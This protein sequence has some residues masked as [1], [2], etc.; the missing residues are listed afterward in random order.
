[1]SEEHRSAAVLGAGVAGL[2]AARALH[3]R[4]FDVT[5]FEARDELGGVWANNYHSLRVLEPNCVY[6]YPDWPWPDG[7]ELFPPASQVREYLTS[8]ARHFGIFER[9]RFGTRITGASPEGSGGWRIEYESE[10]GARGERFDFFVMAPGMF[11]IPKIPDWPER[12]RFA[13]ELI[14]SSQYRD[15]EQV[16]DKR[17]AI[18]GFSRS[19]MDIAVNILDVAASVTI[20]HRSVRWPVPEKILGLIRNHLLLFSRWPTWF[21]PP[22]IRPTP[23]AAFLHGAGKPLVAG[24]WKFFELLL[25][26]QFR[27]RSRRLLPERPIRLDLFTNLYI[28]PPAFFRHVGEGRIHAAR[29]EIEG[30]DRDGL[31]LANGERIEADVVICATGW[32]QDYGFLPAESR[33]RIHDEDGMHLYRHM[34]HPDLP[35]FAFVGGVQGINSATCYAVQAA[36][37]AAVF[38]GDVKLPSADAQR[39]EIEALRRWNEGFVTP[40]PNRSQIL[41]LHQIPYLDDLVADIGRNPARKPFLLNQF[42]PYRSVDYRDLFAP[43]TN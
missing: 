41:N 8:F 3:A 36:W 33:A 32:R 35:G 9:I 15:L 4:G 30:F 5:V 13:G 39:A 42:T 26:G 28:T 22:W 25:A 14:H 27:L 18:V 40:R 29:S 17:V 10:Q 37:L 1:M 12:D 20:V 34:V 16:R 6:G 43:A 38:A 11:N 24:F 7:T 2:A 19:A 31:L 21:A 23:T